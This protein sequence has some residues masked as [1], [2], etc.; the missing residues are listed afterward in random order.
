MDVSVSTDTDDALRQLA[1]G[2]FDLIV[3]D[4]G[5][6][7]GKWAGYALLDVVKKHFPAMPFVIYSASSDRKRNSEAKKRGARHATN[8]AR[9]LLAVVV[10]VLGGG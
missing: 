1:M 8:D 9:D 3:S 7:S 6:P 4:M 10:K 2:N 5:R